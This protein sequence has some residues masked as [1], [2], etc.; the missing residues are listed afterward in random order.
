MAIEF[1]TTVVFDL[2]A[3][4]VVAVLYGFV[5]WTIAGRKV[6]DAGRLPNQSFALWWWG[7]A[8]LTG[9]GV[10]RTVGLGF[11][12][13]T[14]P[15]YMTYLHFVLLLIMVAFAGMLYYFLYL[16][17][18]RN[19]LWVPISLFYFGLYI[20]FVYY[21]MLQEPSGFDAEGNLVYANDLSGTIWG[22]IISVTWLLPPII[23]AGLYLSLVRKVREPLL[24]FRIALVA[25]SIIVWFL[26]VIGGSLTGAATEASDWWTYLSRII[27]ALAA[28][29]TFIAYRPPRAVRKLFNL[30]VDIEEEVES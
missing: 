10:V 11:A 5:A 21:I 3:Q 13:P 24:R 1:T 9:A 8:V 25:S 19:N 29:F 4:A 23:G 27:A 26:I 20:F 12:A 30:E 17:S 18:G 7:L 2:V 28:I 6:S 15:G 14:L 16:W 22:T